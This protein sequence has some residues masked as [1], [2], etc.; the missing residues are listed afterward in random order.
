M[1]TSKAQRWRAQLLQAMEDGC[2]D[3]GAAAK[4]A[5][6]LGFAV[7]V[8]AD[9]VGRA[10]LKAFHAQAHSPLP[11][12]LISDRLRRSCAWFAEYLAINHSSNTCPNDE[13][14]H[15]RLWTDAAGVSRMLAAVV[16]V[17]GCWHYTCD[18]VPEK[19][20]RLLLSRRDNQIGLQELLALPLALG[21]FAPL[22]ENKLVTAFIDNDG[23]LG[24][25]LHGSADAADANFII[26]RF[27]L[28][29]ATLR[30][31]FWALRVESKANLADGPTRDCLAYLQDLRATF[32]SPVWPRWCEHFGVFPD[33]VS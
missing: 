5:G 20:W 33:S 21:T 17:D 1:E 32:W 9:K 7:T 25:V 10:F 18:K 4:L 15:V 8:T 23:V 30:L 6:K 16:C 11:G 27:W 22:L 12:G 26:G 14:P 13:R 31:G 24:S 28:D 3:A 19:V 2:L 29:V